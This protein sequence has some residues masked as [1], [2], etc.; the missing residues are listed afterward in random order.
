MW[1]YGILPQWVNVWFLKGYFRLCS[2]QTTSE[3]A[4]RVLLGGYVGTI[5]MDL[6][7]T[8]DCLSHDLLIAKL[9]TYGL[10]IGSI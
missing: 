9:D 5:L 10:D 6:S 4:G 8:N 2:L 7:K 1:I 3:M